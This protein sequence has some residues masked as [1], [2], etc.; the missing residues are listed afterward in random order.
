MK[1]TVDSGLWALGSEVEAPPEVAVL[2]VSGAVL[3]WTIHDAAQVVRITFTDLPAADWLWR[4]VGEAGHVAVVAAAETAT[5]A[6]SVDL[7]DVLPLPEPLAALRRLAVGHWLR[8]WWPASARDGIAPLDAAVLDAE[9]ALSTAV[10]EDYFSQDTLDSDIAGLLTP[11]REAL[12]RLAASGDPRVLDLVGRCIGLADDAG[13]GDWSEVL[14]ARAQSRRDDYA[15][16][17]G[18]PGGGDTGAIAG[19]VASVSWTAVPPRIFDAAEHT[20]DWSVHARDGAVV[21]DIRVATI[22]PADGIPV[23]LDSG[24]ITGGGTLDVDGNAT[25]PLPATETQA[26]GHDW[27]DTTVT[28]GAQT[29]ETEAVRDR[30]RRYVR[31][32]LTAPGPD[33]F[34]AEILAAEA[35][36]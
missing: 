36:Y 34:L 21:A 4:L 28:V 33:A 1:L 35:D 17:A 13:L 18:Q 24:P 9:V 2:E 7:A 8:R 30:V 22:G 6:G 23:R 29:G 11:H 27:T 12:A 32:R 14:G 25:L 3:A 16:A 26:W 15:L 10:S 31:A 5:E 20:I 19:G